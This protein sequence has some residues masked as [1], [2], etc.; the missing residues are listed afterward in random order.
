MA[1]KAFHLAVLCDVKNP[2]MQTGALCV[3]MLATRGDV[4]GKH[5]G[6]KG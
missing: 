1:G 3:C 4:Q 5:V 2:C 6:V